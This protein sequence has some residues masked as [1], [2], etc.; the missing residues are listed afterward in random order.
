VKST[1]QDKSIPGLGIDTP[2]TPH[3]ADEE[4]SSA[5]TSTPNGEASVTVSGDV[6]DSIIVT[7]D[8]NNVV[9]TLIV[10]SDAGVQELE[11][12]IE[13]ASGSQYLVTS[14]IGDERRPVTSR[15]ESPF[16]ELELHG[17]RSVL[18][19][20]VLDP[21]AREYGDRLFQALFTAPLLELYRLCR[22]RPNPIRLRLTLDEATLEELPW[23][24]LWDRET[25]RWLIQH[26]SVVRTGKRPLAASSSVPIATVSPFRV[27]V[28]DLQ[29]SQ[30]EEGSDAIN[31]VALE[32]SVGDMESQRQVAVSRSS[33][34]TMQD[35]EAAI[36]R[37]AGS[38]RSLD[39]IHVLGLATGEGE[40][41]SPEALA[42]A[43]QRYGVQVVAI[44][45]AP[46]SETHTMLSL[47]QAGP[48][49]LE[50]GLAAVIGAPLSGDDES[51][52]RV[53]RSLYSALCHGDPIDVA[54]SEAVRRRSRGGGG[55][56]PLT[57]IPIC[58]LA[59]GEAV[60][61]DIQSPPPTPLTWGT[62]RPWLRERCT[63]AGVGAAVLALT[64][65]LAVVIP[66][67]WP[68]LVPE[69]IQVMRGTMN[70]AVAE[71]GQ[72]DSN[73]AVQQWDKGAEIASQFS[74][75][76]SERRK[77]LD[78]AVASVAGV[79]EIR[80]PDTTGRIAGKTTEDRERAAERLASSLQADL[81]VSGNVTPDGR[82][83]L[84]E[85][86]VSG[87]QGLSTIDPGFYSFAEIRLRPDANLFSSLNDQQDLQVLLA[88]STQSLVQF[89][90]GTNSYATRSYAEAASHF[91]ESATAGG[92]RLDSQSRPSTNAE[93][94]ETLLLLMGDVAIKQ[95]A[96]P[97]GVQ[98]EQRRALLDDARAQY[99]AALAI[100]P[101]F[102]RA[103][104]GLAEVT[105]L[106]STGTCPR[107][108]TSIDVQ[109]LKSA[110]ALYQ[111]AQASGHQSAIANIDPK[112]HFGIGRATYCLARAG[113]EGYTSAE[114]ERELQRVI[115]A[116]D[117]N[118]QRLKDWA[119]EAHAMTGGIAL[120]DEDYPAA[121][122][123]FSS[124]IALSSSQS[125]RESGGE[126]E[127]RYL[128]CRTLGRAVAQTAATQIDAPSLEEVKR[129]PECE[130][131]F[132]AG[133][134][135]AKEAQ[136]S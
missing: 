90:L 88:Q 35:L 37:A 91:R 134:A 72:I 28:I 56:T 54:L 114:A 40:I 71:F 98:A 52:A 55:S 22:D 89:V 66:A 110:I 47:L 75:D 1:E 125:A 42:P 133:F 95:A 8:Q 32:R 10:G 53:F 92:V 73:G 51:D 16:S 128:F 107:T 29:R 68:I 5:L 96:D 25:S 120:V 123:A 102:G 63:V 81:V 76:L 31:P 62:W 19:R 122:R 36:V 78:D 109:G 99:Q 106:Q 18:R 45:C 48:A 104:V 61:F 7:G 87:R 60:R 119:I 113:A 86:F 82:H 20:G 84:P 41:C 2:A 100:D 116:Y 136:R 57:G 14:S 126:A 85:I 79:V 103:Y 13:R 21:D 115:D 49:L 65:V 3:I 80:S 131:Q 4:L 111:R 6:V 70:I 127:R 11:V 101:E 83:F 108:S 33:P 58:Y 30:T 34:S 132:Q 15:F 43:L 129:E 17:A 112:V 44:S 118:N 12:R 130:R 124:A 24:L 64:V 121:A 69:P 9:G 39:V 26:G 135:L 59:P 23:E 77:A 67:L 50:Q 46:S 38:E 27:L 105:Y 94:L 117:P 93:G 97:S 74:G